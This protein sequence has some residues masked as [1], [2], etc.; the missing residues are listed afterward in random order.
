MSIDDLRGRY[1]AEFIDQLLDWAINGGDIDKRLNRAL[2][3]L[4]KAAPE[5]VTLRDRV[6]AARKALRLGDSVESVGLVVSLAEWMRT[7]GFPEFACLLCGLAVNMRNELGD[8]VDP[9]SA[10]YLSNAAGLLA[11]GFTRLD[12]ADNQFLMALNYAEESEDRGPVPDIL[13]NLV[14]VARYQDR[15]DDA[16]L[17]ALQA[18]QEV[19]RREDLVGQLQFLFTLGNLAID[20]DDIEDATEWLA[21]AEPLVSKA[22]TPHM[23]AGYH[24]LRAL[25]A[26][27]EGDFDTAE[28]A[29]KL[30]L[31]AA[32]RSH[33]QDKQVAALQNLAAV[34]SDAGKQKLA[35]RRI[36]QAADAAAQFHL[37]SRLTHLLPALVRAEANNGDK[38]RALHA[39][40]RL[41]EIA[42]ATQ[43]DLGQAHALFGATLIDNG[44]A[45]EGLAELE[46]AWSYTADDQT[47]EAAELLPHLV[48][49]MIWGSQQAGTL[50]E[51]WQQI[52]LHTSEVPLPARSEL[53]EDLGLL[54]LETSG[55]A[56][57]E[58]TT[59]LMSSLEQRPA[60]A[61]AWAALTAAAQIYTPR[62]PT[63]VA[64]LLEY[65]LAIATRRKQNSTVRHIRNDLSVALLELGDQARARKLLDRNIADSLTDD[66]LRTRQLA[67]F[68]LAE[69]AR[70]SDDRSAALEYAELSLDI[71]VQ[72]ADVEATADAQL[73]TGMC[74]SDLQRYDEARI[75]LEKVVA[76]TDPGSDPH[77]GARRSIAGIELT[78]GDPETAVTLYARAARNER[79]NTIQ[80]LE[81][82]LGWAE[83][84]AAAGN[85]RGYNRMLQRL[86]DAFDTVPYSADLATRFTHVA[87][88]WARANK[89][90][91]AGEVLA[92]TLLIAATPSQVAFDEGHDSD[93]DPV[94]HRALLA[95]ATELYYQQAVEPMGD[96]TQ[97]LAGIESELRRHMKATA[98]RSITKTVKTVVAIVESDDERH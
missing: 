39:A 23:T 98:A 22:S 28:A 54:L 77:L 95:V 44:Q 9:D 17:L 68:N 80:N 1:T 96:R 73:Q 97:V 75:L 61:R 20:H 55:V 29:W 11:F 56:E 65:A 40:Q 51:T 88:R 35:L 66:D 83:A 59:V 86:I 7:S 36:R 48:H 52:V 64:R 57:E 25:I 13:L 47:S 18:L 15:D 30:S 60:A 12:V 90:K 91:F 85:R 16:R 42:E 46:T 14:N 63:T 89:N 72:A 37:V 53:L 93:E 87:R 92:Q 67:Y 78:T 84:L 3:G 50:A 43:T 41:L 69:M 4:A 45:T 62:S 76:T 82:H 27:R 8:E 24:H 70:R 74:L 10:A 79:P 19:E 94:A 2:R 6:S 81:A 58:A 49:N 5:G 21:K 26:S 32:R 38:A 33:D 71:A 31:A 34:A